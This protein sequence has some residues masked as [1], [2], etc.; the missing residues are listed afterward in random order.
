MI[1]NIQPITS[2]FFSELAN[3][4]SILPNPSAPLERCSRKVNPP[5]SPNTSI[6]HACSDTTCENPSI[7]API[8]FH[9]SVIKKPTIA[10][11]SNASNVRFVTSAKTMITIGGISVN[12]PKLSIYFPHNLVLIITTTAILKNILYLY[13]HVYYISINCANF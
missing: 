12:I 10:P 6:I 5:R 9:L 11:M 13:V 3:F 7:V 4:L 1:P 8:T 2:V